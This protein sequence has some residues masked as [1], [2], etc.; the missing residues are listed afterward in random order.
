VSNFNID[1]DTASVAE[2]LDDE[3]DK[4]ETSRVYVAGTNVEYGVYLEF[5]TENMPPYPWARPAIREFKA[6]PEE[7]LLDNTGFSTID[8]IPNG[9]TLVRALSNAVAGKMEDNVNAQDASRD[10]SPGTDPEHPARDTGNLTA[11][12][13]AVRVK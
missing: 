4:W 13:K 5:G 2:S 3:R 10:R 9:D 8:E 7:F 1:L 12:I 6:N 11:D